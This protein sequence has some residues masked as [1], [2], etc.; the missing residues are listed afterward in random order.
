MR[1]FLLYFLDPQVRPERDR[2]RSISP[3][4]RVMPE[5]GIVVG[6]AG[7]ALTWDRYSEPARK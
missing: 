2:A 4:N 5:C 6:T 3:G 1:T 7:P